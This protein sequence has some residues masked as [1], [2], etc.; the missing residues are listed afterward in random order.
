LIL[1]EDIPFTWTTIINSM[2]QM[3][4]DAIK[5][6]SKSIV[7]ATEEPADPTAVATATNEVRDDNDQ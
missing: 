3:P 5:Y 7:D 2:T 6:K 1:P 4:Y